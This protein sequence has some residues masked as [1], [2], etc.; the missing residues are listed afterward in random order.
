VPV[1]QHLGNT[2][3]RVDGGYGDGD[4]LSSHDSSGPLAGFLRINVVT[5]DDDG[6]AAV[7]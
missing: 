2:E 4:E 5:N 7:G 3:P 1:D 6:I